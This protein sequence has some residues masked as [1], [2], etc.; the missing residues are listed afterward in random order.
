MSRRGHDRPG[1]TVITNVRSGLANRSFE[2]R[3]VNGRI[4][5]EAVGRQGLSPFAGASGGSVALGVVVRDNLQPYFGSP[6][7]VISS[8][9]PPSRRQITSCGT[10]SSIAA[11]RDRPA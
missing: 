10:G 1:K 9:R 6:R 11:W 2:A 5:P 3:R 8:I 4:A 7:Q